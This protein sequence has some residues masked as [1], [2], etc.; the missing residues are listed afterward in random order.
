MPQLYVNFQEEEPPEDESVNTA[1]SPSEEES[2]DPT[3]KSPQTK[4]RLPE[5]V[6][7]RIQDYQENNESIIKVFHLSLVVVVILALLVV[8]SQV[9]D[10]GWFLD[11][12]PVDSGPI[13]DIAVALAPL[14]ALMLAIERLVETIFS[15]FESKLESVAKFSNIGVQNYKR[16]EAEL[17][18]GMAEYQALVESLSGATEDERPKIMAAISQTEAWMETINARIGGILKD[19]RY[20]AF[21]QRLS[22]WLG[23]A[24]GFVVAILTDQGIFEYLQIGVPRI[25]DMVIT[26]AVMGAGTGPMHSV[27]GVLDGLKGALQNF[28][29]TV[30]AS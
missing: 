4:R 19:P 22:I 1:V 2:G 21:K 26:G 30:R 10:F 14:L 5:N 12:K 18:S 17:R 27:L 6:K 23:F 28:A 8:F 3:Q 9:G 20:I 7:L 15:Y 24:L 11:T 25:L 13:D 29:P 16:M